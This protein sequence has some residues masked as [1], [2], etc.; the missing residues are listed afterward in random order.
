VNNRSPYR[1]VDSCLQL[2]LEEDVGGI[3]KYNI[4]VVFKVTCSQK[5]YVKSVHEAGWFVAWLNI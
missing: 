4:V 1:Y 3:M 5:A 2:Q